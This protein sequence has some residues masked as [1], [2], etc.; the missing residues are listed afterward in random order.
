MQD[1]EVITLKVREKVTNP[2]AGVIHL[3]SLS[4]NN[5]PPLRSYLITM[6]SQYALV[7]GEEY[8][9]TGFEAR[10]QE[11]LADIVGFVLR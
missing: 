3:I 7:D 10:G 8:T 4:E 9:I 1:P 5:I 11:N 2:R 6:L